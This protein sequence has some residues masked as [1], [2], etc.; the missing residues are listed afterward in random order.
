MNYNIFV[1]DNFKKE[2]KPLLKKYPSLR[3]ELEALQEQL[4]ENPR[5]GVKITENMYK[6]RLAVKS[7]GR[8][9]SGGMRVLTYVWEILTK[10]EEDEDKSETTIFLAAIYDKSEEE[11]I[12]NKDIERIIDEIKDL[13]DE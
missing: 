11:N 1:I 7:K 4:L 2:A 5:M 6:I 13:T 3:N 12:S 8:G 9:K 10:L